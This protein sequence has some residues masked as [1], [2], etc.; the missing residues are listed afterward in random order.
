MRPAALAEAVAAGPG[1]TEGFAEA[2]ALFSVCCV[3]SQSGEDAP[4]PDGL[5]APIPEGA[6]IRLRDILTGKVETEGVAF[7]IDKSARL[8]DRP[9]VG[10]EVELHGGARADGLVRADWF[11]DR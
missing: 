2:S 6:A 5:A 11:C 9:S 1:S 4:D 3:V 8:N 7:D 10:D